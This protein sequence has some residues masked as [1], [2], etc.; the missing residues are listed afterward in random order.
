MKSFNGKNRRVGSIRSA[1][2]L[3][4]TGDKE[5]MLNQIHNYLI[6]KKYYVYRYG[7]EVTYRRGDGFFTMPRY[8]KLIPYADAIMIEA[9]TFSISGKETPLEGFYGGYWKKRTKVDVDYIIDMI[10]NS[11]AQNPNNQNYY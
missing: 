4:H 6:S 5:L 7:E 3:P 8:I 11:Q 10:N 1:I 9:W 2:T